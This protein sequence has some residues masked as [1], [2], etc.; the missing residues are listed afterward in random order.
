MTTATPLAQQLR[1]RER[2]VN[3]FKVGAERRTH[4][5]TGILI[6]LSLAEHR[7]LIAAFARGDLQ[8]AEEVLAEHVWHLRIRYQGPV[9]KDG[10]DRLA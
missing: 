2:A 1:V 3:C 6:Y 5:R 9:R 4:G 7:A 8:R 10:E